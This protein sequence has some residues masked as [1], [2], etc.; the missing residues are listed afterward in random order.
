MRFWG[1][2]SRS[3]GWGEL[4]QAGVRLAERDELA[5]SHGRGQPG[6]RALDQAKMQRAD[7]VAVLLGELQE[8][9]MPQPHPGG[10]AVVAGRGF[11]R[12]RQFIEQHDYAADRVSLADLLE[13]PGPV[14][15]VLT[16]DAPGVGSG[17]GA[18]GGGPGEAGQQD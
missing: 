13:G 1:R 3:A 12:E 16:P 17:S 14:N 18:A 15:Q 5:G 8:R 9:A 6:E 2:E 11:G 7:D 10:H 4:D